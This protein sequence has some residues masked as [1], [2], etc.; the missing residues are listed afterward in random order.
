MVFKTSI[1]IDFIKVFL[2]DF[3]GLIMHLLT[4]NRKNPVKNLIKEKI[5][6]LHH[7]H[8]SYHI[9]NLSR[10]ILWVKSTQEK[11]CTT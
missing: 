6:H 2:D 4:P 11:E 7:T 10:K 9:K 1:H 5:Q 8:I 3:Y